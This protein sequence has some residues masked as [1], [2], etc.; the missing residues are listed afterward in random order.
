MPSA[1]KAKAKAKGP[2][3]SKTKAKGKAGAGAAASA[4]ADAEPAGATKKML[5]PLEDRSSDEGSDS[6]AEQPAI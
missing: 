1:V 3:K 5:V 6:D 4:S 2:A